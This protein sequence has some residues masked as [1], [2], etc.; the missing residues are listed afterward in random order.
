VNPAWLARLAGFCGPPRGVDA[1]LRAWLADNQTAAAAWA[2]FESRA[3]L[4]HLPG[5]EM[6]LVGLVAKRL[7]TIAPTTTLRGRMGGIERANWSR[8]QLAIRE[9]AT[10][11][12]ALRTHDI[13]VMLVGSAIGCTRGDSP[14]RGHRIERVDCCVGSADIPAAH[15]LLLSA[16]W[17]FANI[18]GRDG[19]RVGTAH[20]C[21]F[22][23]G[24][25]G[26]LEVRGSPFPHPVP[27][28]AA[29][30]SVWQRAKPGSLGDASI[31]LPSATDALA[32]T[33]A[34]GLQ[35]SCLTGL[36]LVDVALATCH[37]IDWPFFEE[38][39]GRH[40][41]DAA[42]FYSLHYVTDRLGRS[43]P[44]A[45]LDRLARSAA[46]RALRTAIAMAEYRYGARGTPVSRVLVRV[47][48]RLQSLH[49]EVG[50]VCRP[51]DGP[52]A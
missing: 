10:A 34:D 3:D 44:T 16:G 45:T 7:P 15:D 12:H 41:L 49:P 29:A 24:R 5:P 48:R 37:D 11:F 50:R 46:G 1:L 28:S 19:N 23:R 22:V 40:G 30:E 18:P 13:P 38:Q 21:R 43:V 25:F 36:W 17:K 52:Q 2:D 26:A 9:A 27:D 33:I 14:G 6:C 31:L 20:A 47:L 51:L 32:I 4:D 8:A 39:S 42:A 35:R